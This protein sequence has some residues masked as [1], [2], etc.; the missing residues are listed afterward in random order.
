M[1]PTAKQ[2]EHRWAVDGIE[3]SIARIEEDGV[4]M[5]AVPVHLLPP[6]VREGQL[7]RVTA[8]T[9]AQPDTLVVT[10]ALDVAGT[11]AALEKS[12]RTIAEASKT[13]KRRDPG[14]DVSL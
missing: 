6:G 12:R 13:S 3:E 2:P 10:V 14:G 9:G 5:I 8:A 4:R 1:R 7:L 11:N